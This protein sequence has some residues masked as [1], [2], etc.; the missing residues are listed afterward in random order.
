[1]VEAADTPGGGTRSAALTIPG[2]VHDVCSAVHPMGA[3]SP[4][5]RSFPL[6]EFGVE[7]IHPPAPLAHP[8]LNGPAVLLHRSVEETGRGLGVDQQS[9][10]KLMTP[11]VT[12]WETLASEFLRP[13]HFPRHPV[14][15]AGFGL[16]A[17]RPAAA[18][19]RAKFRGQA[20]RA[21]FAGLAG[22]AILP[23]EKAGSAAFG[24]VLGMMAHAVGWPI[25]RG[26]SQSIPNAL[27][28]YLRSLGGTVVTGRR[29]ENVDEFP[30][31][32]AIVCD[33]TP[34]QLLRLAGYRFT[35]SYRRALQRYRYG[36]G[37]FK[38]D[39]ALR[40]P[41][42]WA[43]PACSRAA[44]VHLGA[45]LEE[46]A[47]SERAAWQGG[48]VERP[49]LIVTQP[50]L[51]DPTRAPQGRH[52]AWAYCHVPN[53]SRETLVDEVESQVER[54]AP[55]FRQIIL[56]RHMFTAA[57]MEEHNPNLVGGDINGGAQDLSQLFLR[58]TRRF[59]RTSAKGIYLCSASTPPGG[60]VHGMCGYF[61]AKA[62]L[63]DEGAGRLG[64]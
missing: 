8:F 26:G 20:A 15:L 47:T 21:L 34:R 24:L 55:G 11:L 52:T 50:S 2:F 9:Y 6:S 16:H 22:H 58:P 61:A 39:W 41:I 4:V 45:S 12:H 40:A 1:M 46:I 60:G 18:F 36:P 42:P 27:C 49:F 53:G 32:R 17:I 57:G 56:A 30:R 37:V 43:D 5:F 23:L 14:Q 62:V 19:A 28:A 59:Y 64:G 25:P 7:W 10:D 48:Y 3:A 63:E 54:F 38:V 35:A 13:I 44:T 33:V 29:V 51:F 31:A